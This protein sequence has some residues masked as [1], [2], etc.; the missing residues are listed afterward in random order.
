MI[1]LNSQKLRKHTPTEEELKQIKRKPLYII[2]E[3]ILDT[4]NVGAIFRLADAAAAS[5]V[6]LVGE[7]ATPDDP[8]I[9]HKIHKA[10]VGTWRWTPWFYT[11]TVKEAVNQIR[12]SKFEIPNKFKI[13][14]SKLKSTKNSVSL[15]NLQTFKLNIVAVEQHPKSVPYNK[16][17]YQFPLAMILGHETTGVSDEALALSDA[18]VEIPMHGVNNSMNVMVSLA[19]VLWYI[20][21][22]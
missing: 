21:S 12:N 4:Y 11:K 7:T 1:K 18:I 9:G 15:S 6:Y 3:N 2:C 14:N 10:S 22:K 13:P 20:L 17:N 5:G 16:Y 8:K 19:I